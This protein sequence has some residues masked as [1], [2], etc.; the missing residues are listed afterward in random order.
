MPNIFEIIDKRGKKTRLTKERWSHIR[1]DHPD[2]EENEIRHT[3]E[4]PLKFV[5]EGKNKFFY[6]QYFKHRKSPEKYLRVIIKYLN[7]E[8]FVVTAHTIK[9]M[10]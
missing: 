7:G 5:D 9:S 1:R 8:G 6:F 10:R 3:I 4:K 2:V